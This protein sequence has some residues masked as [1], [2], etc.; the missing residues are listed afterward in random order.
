MNN[1]N[2]RNTNNFPKYNSVRLPRKDIENNTTSVPIDEDICSN[3]GTSK[4]IKKQNKDTL[5]IEV[6]S[7][8]II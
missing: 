6:R 2:E 4:N 8:N 3:I 7:K 5:L 1:L